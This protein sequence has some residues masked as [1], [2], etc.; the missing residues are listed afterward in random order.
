MWR[1]HWTGDLTPTQGRIKW[2]NP[3][4]KNRPTH[5]HR[6]VQYTLSLNENPAIKSSADRLSNAGFMHGLLPRLPEPD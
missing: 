3:P 2:Q 5:E 6:V 1:N 4:D